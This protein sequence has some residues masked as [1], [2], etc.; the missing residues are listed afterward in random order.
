[1]KP[2]CQHRVTANNSAF[3]HPGAQRFPHGTIQYVHVMNVPAQS[4]AVVSQDEVKKKMPAHGDGK[5][6]D[7]SLPLRRFE[8]ASLFQ[9]F[10]IRLWASHLVCSVI[11]FSSAGRIIISSC[12]PG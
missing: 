1:M 9:T 12:L 11:G 6:C 2:S 4:V 3:A 5:L 8:K 7:Y 10:P